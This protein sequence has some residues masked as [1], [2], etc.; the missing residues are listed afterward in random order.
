MVVHYIIDDDGIDG[1]GN[2]CRVY[3][4]EATDSPGAKRLQ[5]RQQH[6]IP[7]IKESNRGDLHGVV[8]FYLR[9]CCGT[10]RIE[11]VIGMA[12]QQFERVRK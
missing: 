5:G 3:E 11:I 7:L 12:T 1:H 4:R 10:V 6:S 9:G 8:L 2:G